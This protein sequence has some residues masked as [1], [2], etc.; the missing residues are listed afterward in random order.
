MANN[1]K[2]SFQAYAVI[3]REGADDFFLNIGAAFAHR[4][5]N[6]YNVIL[7]ALPID[8]KIVL[9]VPKERDADPNR[10]E[11]RPSESAQ[12]RRRGR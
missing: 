7:Q 11:S 4:D 3:E 10:D 1:Q 6:G 2:S 8:G 5:G 12:P 9:R